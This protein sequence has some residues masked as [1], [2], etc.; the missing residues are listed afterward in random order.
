MIRPLRDRVLVR[1]IEYEHPTLFVA[2]IELHKGEVVAVGPGRRLKRKIP[3][4]LPQEVHAEGRS[5]QPSQTFYV[6]DGP[7][8]GAVVPVPVKVGDIVEYGFR[9]AFAV[10]HHDYT[11]G[12]R[13]LVIWSKNIYG[14]AERDAPTGLLEQTS[15]AID[16]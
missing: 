3:W 10:K 5:I 16:A 6:E 11:H 15:A 9:D 13:L 7:E 14:L 8:T 12:E 2:G 4:L 1:P